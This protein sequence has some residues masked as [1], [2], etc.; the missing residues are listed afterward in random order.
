M[1]RDLEAT[2]AQQAALYGATLRDS[3]RR[4]TE[5]LGISQAAVARTLGVSAPMLSQ[6]LSGQR[7]KFGS[8]LAVQRLRSLLDLADEIEAGLPHEQVGRR[9]EAIGR[10]NSTTLTRRRP[11]GP[12]DVPAA[13]GALLRA[14]ASGRQLAAASECLDADFPE[15]A[16]VLRVY[17]TG[18]P[19]EARAHF[20]GV[21]HLVQPET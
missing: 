4:V 20:E 15:L 19:A 17:G 8:P 10:E 18:S 21:A 11:T 16:T 5:I 12:S 14:V 1:E 7:I 6:L 3:V 2:L 9:L 13:V